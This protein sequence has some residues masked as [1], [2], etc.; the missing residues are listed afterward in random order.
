MQR[1]RT[2][3]YAFLFLA[4][5]S[6]LSASLLIKGLI[7]QMPWTSAG[8]MTSPRS[9]AATV[10]LQDGRLLIT[11]GDNGGGALASAEIFDSSGKFCPTSDP[12]NNFC[13]A[14]SLTFARA[15]HTATVLQDGRVLIAGGLDATG[16]AMDSAEIYDPVANTTTVTGPLMVPRSGH[17]ASLLPDGTVLI[18]G[19]DSKGAALSS[20]EIYSPTNGSFTTATPSLSS[21]REG[22]A[23][24][25][26]Q[27]GRV[28]IVG[29]FD[30]TSVLNSSDIYDPSTGTISAGPVMSTPREGLSATTQLDG[31]V[32]VAGG[33]TTTTDPTTG[34]TTQT[35]LATAEVFDPAAGTFTVRI[36]AKGK[37]LRRLHR[38]GKVK[39]IAKLSY[40]PTG[41]QR[42]TRTRTVRLRLKR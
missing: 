18:A 31:K 39:V 11:G 4:V 41:G 34:A 10:M 16:N 42:R 32:L 5:V 37:R 13:A 7:S 19:G 24:A 22:H 1:L 23:A 14:E 15:K 26:L 25:V 3:K 2:S 8:N 27:D 17:T 21:A 36:A 9:G 33:T 30:G 20:L 29:G 40:T 38:T 28:L 12:P 6:L 35:D